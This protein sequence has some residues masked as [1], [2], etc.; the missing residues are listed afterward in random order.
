MQIYE[1]KLNG[2][3]S[4]LEGRTMTG[5]IIHSQFRFIDPMEFKSGRKI[6]YPEELVKSI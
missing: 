4:E 5:D 6:L 2:N 3:V 1:V